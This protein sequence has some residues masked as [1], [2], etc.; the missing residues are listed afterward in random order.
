MTLFSSSGL[1]SVF[2]CSVARMCF[3]WPTMQFSVLGRGWNNKGL[4]QETELMN[5]QLKAVY[6]SLRSRWR[7]HT[8]HWPV[9]ARVQFDFHLF[10]RLFLLMQTFCQ[11]RRRAGD[12]HVKRDLENI[13]GTMSK[14]IANNGRIRKF[15]L[16]T[17]VFRYRL[18]QWL[19]II[20][21]L[22]NVPG[23]MVVVLL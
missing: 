19:M 14:L 22:I 13:S 9:Y 16:N 20:F 21:L 17:D 6:S 12:T 5:G 8:T 4:K 3:I 1:K 10:D 2:F 23:C 15:Q 7:V 11:L 18:D